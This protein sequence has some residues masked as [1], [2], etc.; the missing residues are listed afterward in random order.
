M[1]FEKKKQKQKK[2][3]TF[4]IMWNHVRVSKFQIFFFFFASRVHFNCSTHV[5]YAL[6][7][8]HPVCFILLLETACQTLYFLVAVKGDWYSQCRIYS[9]WH[10][11]YNNMTFSDFLYN[12]QSKL[13][14]KSLHHCFESAWYFLPQF[15]TDCVFS[16]LPSITLPVTGRRYAKLE[17]WGL[18]FYISTNVSQLKLYFCTSKNKGKI[19]SGFVKRL[20]RLDGF[21]KLTSL[22]YYWECNHII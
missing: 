16:P 2:E 6:C 1:K 11:R 4:F 15:R 21:V 9:T 14:S 10:F 18:H 19:N 5:L 13:A 12:I 3:K 17:H 7:M 22:Q 20:T 8:F